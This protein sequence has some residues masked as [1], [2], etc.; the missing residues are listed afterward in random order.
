MVD[1]KLMLSLLYD[2]AN[3]L[4]RPSWVRSVGSPVRC[5]RTVGLLT[6]GTQELFQPNNLC[7]RDEHNAR[8]TLKEWRQPVDYGLYLALVTNGEKHYQAGLIIK[9]QMAL[10]E[11]AGPPAGYV[12]VNGVATH[13]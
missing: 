3:G 9:E 10:M 8:A 12:S 4:I 6:F 2:A 7:V 11:A 5:L 1:V 13:A